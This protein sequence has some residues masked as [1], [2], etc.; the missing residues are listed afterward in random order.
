MMSGSMVP[1]PGLQNYQ[2]LTWHQLVGLVAQGVLE[3]I[4]IRNG[5]KDMFHVARLKVQQGITSVSEMQRVL[6]HLAG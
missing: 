1:L 6:G 3:E 4:A 2:I 5:F